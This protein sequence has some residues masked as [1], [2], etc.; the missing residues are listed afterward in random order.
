FVRSA[1][2]LRPL[3]D[4]LGSVGATIPIIAK[5]ESQQALPNL[6]E[7]AAAAD[8]VMVARGDLG[9]EMPVEDIPIVQKRIIRLSNAA[10]KPVITATQ[11]LDSMSQRPFP[12]RAE[13][14]DVANAIFDGT[15]AVML[16]A[17]TAIGQFPF[18]TVETMAR[19]AERTEQDLD[20]RA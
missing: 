13:V 9:L 1:A 12:S 14:T 2:D 5:V 7:I 11:M 6:E 10:G 3:R 17:E 16:S 8:G 20:V 19:I 4:L 18:L 15:D